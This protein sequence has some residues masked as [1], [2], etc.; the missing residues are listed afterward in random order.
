MDIYRAAEIFT[1]AAKKDTR[2]V[3]YSELEADIQDRGKDKDEYFQLKGDWKKFVRRQDGFKIFAVDGKWVRDN[4]SIIF[5]HGGHGYVHE[6]IPLDEIWI[7]THHYDENKWSKCGC[8]KGNEPVSK[9]YFDSCIVHEIEEFNLMKDDG[10]PYWPAHQEALEAEEELGLLTS[11]E[12]D[13]GKSKIPSSW[14][15]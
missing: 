13:S 15:G 3:E 4:L 2:K 1:N 14:P 5:G 12:G 8:N 10:K 11:P 9:D 6:F 7:A